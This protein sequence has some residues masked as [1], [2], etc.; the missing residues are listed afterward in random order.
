MR[1]QTNTTTSISAH[2]DERQ[3]RRSRVVGHLQVA[4]LDHV[5]DHVLARRAEQLGVDE[6]AGRRDER[7][8][9]AGHHARHRQRQR[10]AGEHVAPAAVEVVASLQQP[11]VDPLQAR[12]ER[13]DH[14]GQ[15]VVGDAHHDRHGR[16]EQAPVL[17]QDA[18][19]LERVHHE[20]VVLEDRLPRQRAD[21]VGDEERHDHRQQQRVAPLAAAEGDHV[22][23]RVADQQ[24]E[25]RRQP[26][27]LERAQQLLGVVRDRVRV[28]RE[29]PV[30]D[31]AGVERAGLQRLE[32]HVAERQREEDRQPAQPRQQQQVRQPDLAQAGCH[33]PLRPRSPSG[34]P[35]RARAP[36][37]AGCSRKMY[38]FSSVSSSGKIS[39]LAASSGS[40]FSM[41][42][43]T[44]LTGQT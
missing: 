40:R 36:R 37:R 16:V 27:V 29:L 17:T 34:T 42:S 1:A 24:R 7:Q 39:W 3:R 14:E 13:Q 5:A 2:Q 23:E 18:D 32:R 22:R 41:I 30:E 20:A 6:V 44:P 8:Q 12:V 33:Q 43:L 31:V 38:A 9:R 19:R 21:Q 25:D 15:E 35:R 10:H 4:A 28:V 11:R 26:G